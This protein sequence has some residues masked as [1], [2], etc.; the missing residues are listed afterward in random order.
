MHPTV[1]PSEDNGRPEEEE[2]GMGEDEVGERERDERGGA[3]EEVGEMEGER[4]G[5]GRVGGGETVF[6]GIKNRMG[7]GGA[8]EAG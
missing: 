7:Y 1:D 4:G 3:E 2:S 6:F 8:S 5:R